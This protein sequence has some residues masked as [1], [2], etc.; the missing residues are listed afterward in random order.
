[1]AARPMPMPA[2]RPMPMP[3]VQTALFISRPGSPLAGPALYGVLVPISD[4]LLSRRSSPSPR[5][6]PYSSPLS[7]T[8]PAGI[9][10]RSPSTWSAGSNAAGGPARLPVLNSPSASLSATPTGRPSS[11][12]SRPALPFSLPG[13]TPSG[14]GATFQVDG[15]GNIYLSA[16]HPGGSAERDGTM[17]ACT[18]PF[19]TPDPSNNVLIA[20]SMLP[21]AAELTQLSYGA[22]CPART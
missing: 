9:G 5:T 13:A 22:W 19:S 6:S 15:L 16:I 11:P 3:G 21:S 18:L 8:P 14:I 2:A 1:M 4:Q 17:Q 20:P 10:R 12:A 7:R